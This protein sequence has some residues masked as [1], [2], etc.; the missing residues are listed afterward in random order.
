M[1]SKSEWHKEAAR[2]RAFTLIELLV[3][4]LIMAVIAAIAFPSYQESVR[5]TRR[6][7]GRAALMELMQQQERYYSRNNTYVVFSASASNGF[8]WH[9]AN[10]AASSSYEIDATACNDDVIQNC[11]LITAKPGTEKVNAKYRDDGCGNLTLASTGVKGASGN[12]TSCW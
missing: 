2:Y 8:K 3:V 4:M 9:S 5:K 6:A 11:V 12:A 10:D 1:Q 7:E